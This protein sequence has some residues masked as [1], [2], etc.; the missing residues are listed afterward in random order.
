M[1]DHANCQCK[2]TFT[3]QLLHYFYCCVGFFL[4]PP[5]PVGCFNSLLADPPA[6]YPY[7]PDSA[8]TADTTAPECSTAEA[9]Y[10]FTEELWGW[11]SCKLSPSFVN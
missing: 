11:C 7:I 8:I 5:P 2:Y 4:A 1:R 6:G 3:L 9:R 10:S